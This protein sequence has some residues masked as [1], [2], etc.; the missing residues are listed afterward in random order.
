MLKRSGI[1][2]WTVIAFIIVGLVWQWNSLKLPTAPVASEQAS[3]QDYTVSLQTP[4]TDQPYEITAE[5]GQRLTA[6][7]ALQ[8]VSER[9]TIP[10]SFNPS[11]GMG[12]FV[13][14]IAGFK[15]GT[16]GRYWVYEINDQQVPLAADQYTLAPSDRLV[17]KFT[18]PD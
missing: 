17:W 10:M 3:A 16:G 7:S 2:I 1:I 6:F 8:K 5:T 15:N 14:E 4:A 11:T 13:T 12:V 9:Y 18:V